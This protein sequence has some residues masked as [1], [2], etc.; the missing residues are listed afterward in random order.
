MDVDLPGTD[1]I[2][3]TGGLR[4]S[5]KTRGIPIITI[6]DAAMATDIYRAEGAGF[7][8]CFTK[9][10]DVARLL[11]FPPRSTS[12]CVSYWPERNRDRHR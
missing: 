1:G 11:N 6:T 10:L 2:E 12:S 7:F 3:A 5:D 8:A 9:P 4:N